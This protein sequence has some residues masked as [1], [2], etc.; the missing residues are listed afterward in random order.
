LISLIRTSSMWIFMEAD[1][2]NLCAEAKG[3]PRF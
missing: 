2:L 3:E 1:M